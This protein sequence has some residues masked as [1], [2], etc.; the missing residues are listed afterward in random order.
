MR[1]RGR[2]IADGDREPLVGDRGEG[3]EVT[4]RVGVDWLLV[5][6]SDLDPWL[7]VRLSLGVVTRTAA[8]AGRRSSRGRCRIAGRSVACWI[9]RGR[10]SIRLSASRRLCDYRARGGW[11]YFCFARKGSTRTFLK[12]PD[13]MSVKMHRVWLINRVLNDEQDG[14][15]ALRVNMGV[16]DWR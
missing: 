3:S 9:A 14:V 5:D 7:C 1:E 11:C 4:V 2:C 13:V 12:N 6:S 10:G 15:D 16:A 8:R